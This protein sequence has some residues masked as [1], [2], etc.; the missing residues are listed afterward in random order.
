MTLLPG[1]FNFDAEKVV[2]GTIREQSKHDETLWIQEDRF[3]N[4][5]LLTENRK[6]I[7]SFV[8]VLI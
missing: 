2:Y 3:L 4:K 5:T 8:A 7:S 1:S 6:N